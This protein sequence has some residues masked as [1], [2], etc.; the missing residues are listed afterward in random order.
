MIIKIDGIPKPQKRHRHTRQGRVYD[1]SK[2]DKMSLIAELLLTSPKTPFKKPLMIK[3]L[4]S[5]PRPKSHFRTGKFKGVLK[6]TAPDYASKKP[7]I[8]NLT[9]IV[10]DCME[11]SGYFKNDSQVVMLQAEKVYGEPFTEIFI[12]EI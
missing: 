8:D 4:F 3:L 7:D 2:K 1:P 11:K 5:M 9:K 6:D 10:L 12:S